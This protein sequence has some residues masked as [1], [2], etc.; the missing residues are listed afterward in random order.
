MSVYFFSAKCLRIRVWLVDRSTDKVSANTVKYVTATVT[1]VTATD[2]CD[3][4]VNEAVC[5]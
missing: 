5:M 2:T 1:H 3:S 4:Y